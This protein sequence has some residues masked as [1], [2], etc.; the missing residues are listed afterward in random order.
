MIDSYPKKPNTTKLIFFKK[1]NSWPKKNLI[2]K[3]YWEGIKSKLSAF[4][5]FRKKG[6]CYKYAHYSISIC[7]GVI[8]WEIPK[9]IAICWLTC[10][11][12]IQIQIIDKREQS[13]ISIY[14][15]MSFSNFNYFQITLTS[16]H[17]I[18]TRHKH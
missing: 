11:I 10:L 16:L 15:H 7:V 14:I 3:M 9:G 12:Q 4:L 1:K 2:T 8:T 17:P 13:Y 6:S 5:L 18:L